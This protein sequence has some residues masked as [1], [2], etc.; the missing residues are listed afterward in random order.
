MKSEFHQQSPG[1][2]PKEG[3][4]GL[5]SKSAP[6]QRL[7]A[8]SSRNQGC[9]HLSFLPILRPREKAV[10]SPTSPKVERALD[11]EWISPCS[12]QSP[13]PPN[14]ETWSKFSGPQFA[15]LLKENF[16]Y[17]LLLK[18][19]SLPGQL[20]ESKWMMIFLAWFTFSKS[21]VWASSE[22]SS[23]T[24]PASPSTRLDPFPS[25]GLQSHL[26]VLLPRMWLSCCHCSFI[27]MNIPLVYN[28]LKGR[29]V[30]HC[31]IPSVDSRLHF[32][33]IFSKDTFSLFCQTQL[34]DLKWWQKCEWNRFNTPRNTIYFA[35][36]FLRG[37]HSAS[38]R[39]QGAKVL[40]SCIFMDHCLRAE[41]TG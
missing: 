19:L 23:M 6:I 30:S 2:I 25:S 28:P 32:W 15:C 21:L 36:E 5:K 4:V 31:I 39:L 7:S 9:R 1:L 27:G 29:D 22:K 16:F 18:S 26:W 14:S 37:N 41:F 35:I 40:V 20:W 13:Q 24:S 11:L 12:D 38:C 34:H 10:P 3:E 17:F 33:K 8:W